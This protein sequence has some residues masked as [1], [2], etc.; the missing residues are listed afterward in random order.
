MISKLML[1]VLGLASLAFVSAANADAPA[2][3]PMALNVAQMD[4]VT[5]AGVP[6]GKKYCKHKQHRHYKKH[7]HYK[8]ERC[9]H[10][11]RRD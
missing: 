9:E 7:H 11:D 5:A 2:T 3:Q 1:G 4:S 6:D 8:K 10:K